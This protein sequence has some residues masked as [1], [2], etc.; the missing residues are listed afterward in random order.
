MHVKTGGVGVAACL[1]PEMACCMGFVG[2]FI[3]GKTCVP[4]N[5]EHG[6]AMWSRI[7]IV[8]RRDRMQAWPYGADVF[9]HG[10]NDRFVVAA[11]VGIE[12]IAI[13]IFLEFIE[14]AEKVFWETFK[15]CHV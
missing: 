11:L 13:I 9:T 2:C 10:F 8:V 15:F 7:S 5:P 3:L 12:P 1:V 14:E 6:T 4:I